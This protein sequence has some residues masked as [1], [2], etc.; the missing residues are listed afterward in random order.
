MRKP[1]VLPCPSKWSVDNGFVTPPIPT[2][3]SPF[4][5]RILSAVVDLNPNKSVV[6]DELKSDSSVN[7]LLSSDAWKCMR[8]V[9]ASSPPLIAIVPCT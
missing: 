3:P 8:A 7:L 2:L 6:V 1:P 4:K 5:T 9:S